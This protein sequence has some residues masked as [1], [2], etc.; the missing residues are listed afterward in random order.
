VLLAVASASMAYAQAPQ[1]S[2]QAA[3]SASAT[4]RLIP[5]SGTL[6]ADGT[7]L[8][9]S[10]SV[11]F[12]LYEAQEGGDA[13]WQETQQLTAD[14]RGRYS[15]Y[16]GATSP[17]PQDAFANEKA[18]WLGVDAD[19]HAQRRVMLVA[20]PYALRAVDADTLG[21]KP[22]SSFLQ[23][24][25]AGRAVRADGI[26]VADALVGGT[27][28]PNQLVKW[29]GG[30]TVSSSIITESPANR[31]GIGTTDPDEG[32]LLQ[33]KVTIRSPDTLTALAVANQ[34]GQP[35]WAL[36][37]YA[38]GSIISFDRAT[39]DYLPGW[40]QRGGRIGVSAVDPTG[41]G[42]VDSKLTVR[43]LDNNTGFAI[44]NEANGRRFAI[45]TL[46]NGGWLMYD[47][48]NNTWNPGLLQRGGNVL[49]GTQ[50]SASAKF[51]VQAST[52]LF[53]IW[54]QTTDT[55]GLAGYATTTGLGTLGQS[56]DGIGLYGYSVNGVGLRVFSGG[57]IQAVFSGFGNVGISTPN[58]LDRLH[59]ADDIRVGSGMTGCVKDADGTVIAGT[60]ASDRRFKKG[61]S[62]FGA[63][64]DKVARL[65]PVHFYWRS[66]EFP[67]KHFGNSESYG[68]IAQEVEDI[69][70]ELVT[71]D[72]KGYKAV[73]YSAL[74]LH[75]LQAIKE[76][77]GENDALK[78]ELK[79]QREAMEERL[80]RLEAAIIK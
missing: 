29:T 12:S 65:R 70:P 38:D 73:R 61:V 80:R 14:A 24:D 1:A 43:N 6:T 19:G 35:R 77:K 33:S 68:L 64:L 10:V 11:T 22:V 48:G 40:V 26:V 75:M 79:A 17:L 18:R 20:V 16:L 56:Q 5:V 27:G 32:G 78:A 3:V 51:T 9:G 62:P 8:R 67:D 50:T 69:L 21:G 28:V 47:G 45:N 2:P 46:A 39:G 53:G 30:E 54:A 15:A 76:L 66:D 57:P 4:T 41:G 63:S 49:L 42:V 34:S 36:N 58:P 74:P 60:C 52:G 31:I 59:V 13:I 55:I 44:L 37:T 23:A 7:A 71:V 25:A 72:E